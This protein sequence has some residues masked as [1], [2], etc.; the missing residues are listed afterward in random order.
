[1][2]AGRGRRVRG[3]DPK[4]TP[5]RPVAPLQVHIRRTSS[6]LRGSWGS[7]I[8][9]S[10]PAAT[11]SVAGPRLAGRTPARGRRAAGFP[12]CQTSVTARGP[13]IKSAQRS[14][15][16]RTNSRSCRTTDLTNAGAL[17]R[18]QMEFSV[19]QRRAKTTFSP[20]TSSPRS[21]SQSL[22]AAV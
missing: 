4:S 1:M 10:L 21:R 14:V 18:S 22:A 2:G 19:C 17:G 7:L 12:K 20:R 3:A 15:S 13:Q 11:S 5:R 6:S 8:R 16:E 9:P